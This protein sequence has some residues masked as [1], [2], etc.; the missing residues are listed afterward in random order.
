METAMTYPHSE[1][2]PILAWRA[3]LHLR[4]WQAAE[5]LGISRSTVQRLAKKPVD[6][7]PR[8]VALALIGD[9]E[10]RRQLGPPHDA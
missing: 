2:N 7:L 5:R 1:T 6:S 10:V 3:D 8:W 9:Y 4:W